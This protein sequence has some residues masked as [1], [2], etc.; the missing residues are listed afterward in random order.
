MS[1]KN[2][3]NRILYILY[4][5]QKVFCNLIIFLFISQVIGAVGEMWLP[6]IDVYAITSIDKI[7]YSEVAWD[8]IEVVHIL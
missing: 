6:H 2:M 5:V 1:Q 4:I 7:N 3:R 8:Y